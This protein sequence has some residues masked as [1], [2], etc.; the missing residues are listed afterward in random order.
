MLVCNDSDV[1]WAL[2]IR[3]CEDFKVDAN[4]GKYLKI[5]FNTGHE[6]PDKGGKL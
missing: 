5:T 1:L 2:G 4:T 3:R 6:V